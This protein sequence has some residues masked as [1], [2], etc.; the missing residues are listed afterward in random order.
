MRI[1][2]SSSFSFRAATALA[3]G[4]LALA[5]AGC[6]SDGSLTGASGGPAGATLEGSVE[7]GGS[8]A[9]ASGGAAAAA[10]N[11]RVSVVGSSVSATTDAGGRFVL[12]GVP[13]GVVTLRFEGDGVDA[14]V[15]VTGLE[16][17]RVFMVTIRIVGQTATIV[18]GP[19]VHEEAAEFTGT[20]EDMQNANLL[21]SGRRVR[22]NAHTVFGPTGSVRSVADLKVGDVVLVRGWQLIDSAV[23]A[24]EVLR[25]EQ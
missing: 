14:R 4:A 13:A 6:D 1:T 2:R 17:G 15:Q 21:V 20:I 16:E 24:R 7:A 3:I 11:L 5:G 9:A 8:A 25:R 18:S 19:S 23:L 22:T 10:A 12:M